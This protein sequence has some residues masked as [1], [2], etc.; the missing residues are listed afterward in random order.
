M[1]LSLTLTVTHN[2]I[3]PFRYAQVEIEILFPMFTF[4]ISPAPQGNSYKRK[5]AKC[6]LKLNN[7]LFF[8]FCVKVPQS[9]WKMFVSSS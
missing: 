5:E 1:K 2:L 8:K 6:Y 7:L 9:K 4:K 3:I